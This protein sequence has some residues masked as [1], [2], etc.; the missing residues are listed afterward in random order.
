MLIYVTKGKNKYR[1]TNPLLRKLTINE[2][3]FIF[4]K[5]ILTE[6]KCLMLTMI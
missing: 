5:R 3:K 1:F 6:K 2:Y 4:L